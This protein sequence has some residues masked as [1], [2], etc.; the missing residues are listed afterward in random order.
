MVYPYLTDEQDLKKQ[1]ISE[2]V[3]V[4]TY[5]PNVLKLTNNKE[6]EYVFSSLLLSLPID[7]RYDKEDMNRIISIVHH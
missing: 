6:S 7:Q 3:F 1:F 5:W 4:A 2:K